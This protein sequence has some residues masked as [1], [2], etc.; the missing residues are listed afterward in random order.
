MTEKQY[1]LSEA[2]AAIGESY[3]RCWHAYADKKLPLPRR[4]GRTFV[5]TDDDIAALKSCLRDQGEGAEPKPS[6]TRRK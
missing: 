2:A 4:V 6:V 1:S 5:L 3:S